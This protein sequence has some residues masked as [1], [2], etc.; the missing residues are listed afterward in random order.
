MVRRGLVQ[1]AWPNRAF[2][3]DSLLLVFCGGML[4]AVFSSGSYQDLTMRFLLS[5]LALGLTGTQA[6][7]RVFGAERAVFWRESASGISVSAYFLGKMT[8]FLVR[9]LTA[10]LFFLLLYYPLTAPRFPFKEYYEIFAWANLAATSMGVFISILLPP[11][12]AFFA[13]VIVSL[14]AVLFGGMQPR[15]S[16]LE[17][18]F[19][20]RVGMLASYARWTTEAQFLKELHGYPT[21]A[22]R[23]GAVQNYFGRLGYGDANDYSESY[24]DCVLHLV[25][26]SAVCF[27]LAFMLM[28]RQAEAVFAR[29]G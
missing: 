1:H 2:M 15:V 7:M 24:R 10:P 19:V 3:I 27:G 17:K 18:N 14:V 9:M 4:G 26:I 28:H 11:R 21:A 13:G 20:G 29:K 8:A 25:Y 16:E 6:A 23:L 12:S 5:S 22:Y